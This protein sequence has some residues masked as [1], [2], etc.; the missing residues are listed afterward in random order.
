MP[1]G[2]IDIC[3][4]KSANFGVVIAAMEVIQLSL[5]V[6]H[7]GAIAQRVQRAKR[8]CQGSLRFGIVT[9]GVVPVVGDDAV[10]RTIEDTYDITLDVGDAIIGAVQAAAAAGVGLGIDENLEISGINCAMF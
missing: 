2:W 3:I 7:I 6:V 5:L 1:G 10:A 9:P 8:I 4:D